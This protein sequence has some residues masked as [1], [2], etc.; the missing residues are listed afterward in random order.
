MSTDQLMSAQP[1]L[2]PQMNGF[3]LTNS[4]KTGATISVDHFLDQVYVFL[5]CNL[6]L[7]DI[8]LVKAEYE[9]F[10]ATNGVTVKY[11]NPDNG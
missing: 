5:T 3:F 4:R 11:F 8:F 1:G 10:L 7:K 6:I 2:I 9:P